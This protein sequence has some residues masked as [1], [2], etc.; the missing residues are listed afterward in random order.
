[1]KPRHALFLLALASA[2]AA[3]QDTRTTTYQTPEGPLTVNWGQPPGRDFGPPPPFE[4]LATDGSGQITTSEAEAYPPLANDFIHAD[5]N[6]DM[7][8]SRAE[9]SRWISSN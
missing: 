2:A 5:R 8:V 6:R 9:Y 3:A 1:M 4:Q 7:R